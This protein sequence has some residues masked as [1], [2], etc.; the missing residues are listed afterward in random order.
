MQGNPRYLW[1][2]TALVSEMVFQLPVFF[3]GSIGLWNG[4]PS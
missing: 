2:K 3:F 1:F 4:K